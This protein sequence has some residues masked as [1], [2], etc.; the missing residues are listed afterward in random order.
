M[1]NTTRASGDFQSLARQVHEGVKAPSERRWPTAT[2]SDAATAGS[3]NTATSKAHSGLSLTDAVRG[4]GGKG[5]ELPSEN[6]ASWPSPASRDYRDP[7]AKS[8]QERND[9]TAGEQLPNFLAHKVGEK[10]HLSPDWVEGL[11][12]F[13]M[14]W[15]RPRTHHAKALRSTAPASQTPMTPRWACSHCAFTVV[16]RRRWKCCPKC[17]Q[18]VS[19]R[20]TTSP[21]TDGPLAPENH[22]TPT[23]R[24]GRRRRGSTDGPA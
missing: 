5:R 17:H 20:D 10:G 11:M 22:S 7:N 9:T 13:Q 3:R 18:S 21:A 14:G 23:S 15:T 1:S 8:R 6:L 24:R 4:D 16:N 19:W 2:S 12:G